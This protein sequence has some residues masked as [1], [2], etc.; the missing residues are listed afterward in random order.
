MKVRAIIESD[1]DWAAD[2]TGIEDELEYEFTLD[3]PG[4]C[5]TQGQKSPFNPSLHIT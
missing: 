5:S 3:C 2:G 4:P 1:R